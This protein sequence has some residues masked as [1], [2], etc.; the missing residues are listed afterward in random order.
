MIFTP[1]LKEL[2]EKKVKPISYVRGSRG[3]EEADKLRDA[4]GFCRS[5]DYEWTEP[6]LVSPM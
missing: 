6:Q 5:I 2:E 3:P 4:F 1:L